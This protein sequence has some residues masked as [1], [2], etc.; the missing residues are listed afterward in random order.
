MSQTA[1]LIVVEGDDMRT[2]LVASSPAIP[3]HRPN[4][5]TCLCGAKRTTN[6]FTHISEVDCGECLLESSRFWGLPGWHVEA[7]QP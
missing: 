5:P 6:S 7:A 1:A 2:H 3:G 4:L